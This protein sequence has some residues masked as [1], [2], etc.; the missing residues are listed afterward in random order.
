MVEKRGR[1]RPRKIQNTEEIEMTN[2]EP[3]A[4]SGLLP[5]RHV[6]RAISAMGVDDPNGRF[7]SANSVELTLAQYY[8]DGYELFDTHFLGLEPD[9]YNVM[10]ILKLK[11]A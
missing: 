1:G 3:K 5:V 4:I 7:F 11:E 8:A 6:V 9:I 2:V 10:Y